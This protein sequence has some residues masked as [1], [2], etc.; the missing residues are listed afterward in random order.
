MYA[1]ACYV[2]ENYNGKLYL[3]YINMSSKCHLLCIVITSVV[4]PLN[5]KSS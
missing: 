1:L 3:I 4:L 5:Y 2:D